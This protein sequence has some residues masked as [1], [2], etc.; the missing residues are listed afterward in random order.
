MKFL[1]GLCQDDV[2][3]SSDDVISRKKITQSCAGENFGKSHQRNFGNLL[4][5]RSYAAKSRPGGKFTPPWFYV[6]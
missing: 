2:T 4:W 6:C 3:T 5:F 1:T